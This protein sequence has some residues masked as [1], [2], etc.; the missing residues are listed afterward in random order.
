MRLVQEQGSNRTFSVTTTLV[1]QSQLQAEKVS[2]NEKLCKDIEILGGD[3]REK[4][5]FFDLSLLSVFISF[6][7]F[8]ITIIHDD[9]DLIYLTTKGGP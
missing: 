3:P 6:S 1:F 4:E 9:D 5:L 8:L 7:L 2:E